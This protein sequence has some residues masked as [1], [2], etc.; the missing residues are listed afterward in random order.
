LAVDLGAPAT[1]DRAVI[2]W[3]AAAGRGYAIQVSDDGSSWHTVATYPHP[4][5]TTTGG[6]LA[7]DGRAAL[8]VRDAANPIT[9]TGDVVTLSDGPAA[10]L[11]VE[12]YPGADASTTAARHADPA[13]T[14]SDPLVR[15]S[16]AEGFLSLFN[17]GT[18]ATTATVSISQDTSQVAVYPGRQQVT[19]AGVE[20][21]TTLPA[22]SAA[23]LPVRF[24]LRPLGA[25]TLPAGLQA[26]VVDAATVRLSGPRCQVQVSSPTT[27]ARRAVTVGSQAQDVTFGEVPPY[28]LADLALGRVTF[29]TDPLPPGMTDPAAV[30]DGDPKTAWTPGAGGRVVIDLG[31]A[32]TIA[33]VEFD[34]VGNRGVPV[35]L[36][37]STDGIT[38]TDPVR[39]PARQNSAPLSTSARY[40]SVQVVDWPVDG[41]RLRRLSVVPA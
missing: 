20:L 10:P 30:V 39:L 1:I 5:L 36:A 18:T 17:L 21:T 22:A 6:W 28:P 2:Y 7:V 33:R 13:P 24:L 19:E 27:A 37:T 23:V 26:E 3:E 9:V 4:D 29:P 12:A 15:A 35:D 16:T 32:H 31:S 25:A 8:V 14:T 11:L 40:V 34:W 38:Y 41:P